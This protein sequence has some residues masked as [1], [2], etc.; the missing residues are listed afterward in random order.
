MAL[1]ID[2]I[3][4]DMVKIHQSFYDLRKRKI[5]M[6]YEMAKKP[7]N[8]IHIECYIILRT[9][10]DLSQHVQTSTIAKTLI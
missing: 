5:Y 3:S 8:L 9:S 7:L 10:R 4:H 6:Y 2:L 1:I